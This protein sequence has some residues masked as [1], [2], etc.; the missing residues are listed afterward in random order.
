[1][2]GIILIGKDAGKLEVLKNFL[3]REFEIK[4]LEAPRY[5]LG[6]QFARSKKGIFVSRRKYVLD[7]LK[8]TGL[9][10]CKPVGTLMVPNLRL[11]PASVDKVVNRDQYQR[12][13]GRLIYLS[14]TRPIIAFVVSI[15][16]Q[17]M[18]SLGE[19]HFEVAYRILKYLKRKLGRG[20][21]FENHDHSR[22][23][24][25]TNVDWASII[26]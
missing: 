21:L 11:Q 19:E 22:I 26:D 3:A 6:M 20:L 12:L 13:V 14:H 16:S 2:D 18:H 15:V 24:A 23:E 7:L 17:Y 1:M 4:D 25:Y 8:E 5:F 9:L 10:G